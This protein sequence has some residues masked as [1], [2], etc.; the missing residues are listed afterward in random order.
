MSCVTG[1]A[2]SIWKGAIYMESVFAVIVGVGL[3]ASCGFRVFVPMLVVSAAT[4]ASYVEVGEGFDWIGTRT[5]F[6]AFAVASAIESAAYY[7][8]Y[9]DNLLDIIASPVG[10]IAGVVVFAAYVSGF[11]PFL[12]W[13]LAVIAGGGSAAVVQGGTVVIR[14]ASTTTTGG[15]ANFS[16][17]TLETVAGFFFS[18]MSIVVPL[19]TIILLLVVTGCMY[20]I[21]RPILR[22]LFS[23]R[24]KV[25]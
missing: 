16:V 17:S 6:V 22:T 15:L 19:L 12:Q 14:A 7:V 20:Y 2:V 3:A 11:D 8:P 18:V 13:S 10:V 1:N 25:K 4:N 5:A 23:R 24:G 21:G 9:L